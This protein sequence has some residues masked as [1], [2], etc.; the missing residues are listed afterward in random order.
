M[1]SSIVVDG[2]VFA[3]LSSSRG[4]DAGKVWRARFV[5]WFASKLPGDLN[6]TV[7]TCPF[8]LRFPGIGE[9]GQR[10]K[11]KIIVERRATPQVWW[12]IIFEQAGYDFKANFYNG[13]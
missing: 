10:E 9:F 7:D 2:F 3:A 12:I 4:A 6:S 1:T 5:M 11:V 13:G 8:C